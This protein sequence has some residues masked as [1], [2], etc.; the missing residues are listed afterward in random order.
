MHESKKAQLQRNSCTL[1]DHGFGDT[2]RN[3]ITI[4]FTETVDSPL[5]GRPLYRSEAR[6]RPSTSVRVASRWRRP[7]TLH[8]RG[9]HLRD[10]RLGH[11]RL[12]PRRCRRRRSHRLFPRDL[13]F[14]VKI[15]RRRACRCKVSQRRAL[16][17]YFR[18]TIPQ[19]DFFYDS[20]DNEPPRNPLGLSTSTS[21]V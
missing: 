16:C 15:R 11:E 21:M 9:H 5:V 13:R 1:F 2:V 4:K 3:I 10:V 19:A 17:E 18:I 12:Y 20:D 7:T 6:P 8:R 14:L